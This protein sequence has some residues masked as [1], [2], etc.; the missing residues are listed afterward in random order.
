MLS[1]GKSKTSCRYCANRHHH[2]LRDELDTTR[3]CSVEKSTEGGDAALTATFSFCGVAPGVAPI[4]ARHTPIFLNRC[5]RLARSCLL[6]KSMSCAS[7]LATSRLQGRARAH[8]SRCR[9][10]RRRCKRDLTSSGLARAQV[11]TRETQR[12]HRSATE[13]RFWQQALHLRLP[14]SPRS[15]LTFPIPLVSLLPPN[16]PEPF[17]SPLVGVGLCM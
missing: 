2:R 16:G 8:V 14:G 4:P 17:E 15:A 6:P 1:K 10:Y 12:W 13:G 3:T 7:E 11:Y 5:T 9:P